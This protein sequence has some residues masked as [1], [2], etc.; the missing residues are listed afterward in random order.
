MPRHDQVGVA[1]A[2]SAAACFGLSVA[3]AKIL[4]NELSW[5]QMV[6]GRF[7]IASAIC[8][9]IVAITRTNARL[10]GEQ[11]RRILTAGILVAWGALAG[12][13]ALQTV[14]AWLV[15]AVLYA[16]PA[17]VAQVSNRIGVPLHGRLAR[18]SLGLAF[19]GVVLSVAPDGSSA[20]W[21]GVLAAAT[22][23]VAYAALYATQGL[24]AGE[25]P[26]RTGLSRAPQSQIAPLAYAGYVCVTAL[27]VAAPV[28]L[29]VGVGPFSP[30][31]PSLLLGGYAV[32][33]AAA[34]LPLAYAAVRNLGAA[35]VA[36]LST[37]EV[38]AA[39][40][41]SVAILGQLPTLV[42]ALG[43][44]MIV[45][46]ALLIASSSRIRPPA[47]AAYTS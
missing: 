32:I 37:G 12:T 47:P 20:S 11:A 26:G 23:P 14:P 40:I 35:R 7:L 17:L 33:A 27:A 42:Q 9:A 4:L 13:F 30:D 21:L 5:T 1:Y 36:V 6:L 28:C 38:L 18:V 44:A 19:G 45:V 41:A 3:V 31:P 15:V 39:I 24:I 46:S 29:V 8:W 43:C 34:P 22:T 2:L 16:Y 25:A 10:T